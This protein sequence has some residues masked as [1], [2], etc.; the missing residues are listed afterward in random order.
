MAEHQNKFN[1]TAVWLQREDFPG[2]S[3]Y[4]GKFCERRQQI[5]VMLYIGCKGVRA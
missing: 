1:Y 3:I 4:Q 2:R 5:S